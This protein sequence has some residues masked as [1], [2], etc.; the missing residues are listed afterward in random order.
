MQLRPRPKPIVSLTLA[1]PSTFKEVVRHESWRKTMHSEYHALC[2][3]NTW[4]LVPFDSQMNVIGCKWVFRIKRKVDGTIER[5]KARLVAKGFHQRHGLDYDETFSPVV[6]PITLRLILSIAVSHDWVIK[7][8]DVNNAFLQGY[9]NETVYMVQPPGFVDSSRPTH[10]CK[11]NRSLYGLKQAPRAWFARLS[12]FL[13]SIGF[14]Q[15]RNDASLFV[16]SAPLGKVYI[17]INVDDFI[18]TGSNPAMVTSLIQ[19]LSTTF[20]LKDLG[21]LNYFLG[22]E[23]L[24]HSHGLLL[25]QRQYILNL[26]SS[27]SMESAK[28]VLTPTISKYSNTK[29][30][31]LPHDD[32][33]KFRQVVGSLQYLSLTRPDIAFAV[34]RVC[35]HM[36]SPQQHHWVSVKRILCY[37]QHTKDHG[38]LLTKSSSD[39]LQLFTD[40]DWAGSSEDRRSTAG[41]ALY[42]GPTLISWSSRKQRTVARSSTEAEYKALADAAAELKWVVSLLHELSFPSLQIP[43]LWCDNNGAKYLATNPVFHARTKHIEIDFHFVREMVARKEIQILFLSTEDQLADVLTKGLPVQRFEYFKHKLKVVQRP[44]SA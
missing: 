25:S 22:V 11:L 43:L 13:L 17:L 9:L 38:L 24:H 14:H 29:D 2:S 4:T 7:Q 15:S 5:Y 32:P 44:P 35:Q 1:E 27:V 34:N 16:H 30:S 6:K 36:H 10:V 40:A 28:P 12:S 18:I 3:N 23:V 33:R 41:Y 39:R 37:L 21:N 26:L 42:Y 8:L 19:Q 20:S 31:T